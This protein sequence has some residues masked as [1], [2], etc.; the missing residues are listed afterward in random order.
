[1]KRQILLTENDVLRHSYGKVV[2]EPSTPAS[3]FIAVPEPILVPDPVDYPAAP[4]LP[5]TII[6]Q[7]PSVPEV[8]PEPPVLPV[9]EPEPELPELE[10]ESPVVVQESTVS[11]E[12]VAEISSEETKVDAATV[13]ADFIE[14]YTKSELVKIAQEMGIELSGNKMQLAQRLSEAGAVP[15]K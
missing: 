9:V 12:E 2:G 11:T 13:T 3:M 10:V 15:S 8:L 4:S 14:K 7:E 5:E 6:T 1:M